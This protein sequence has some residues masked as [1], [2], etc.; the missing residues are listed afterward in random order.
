MAP[1]AAP[2]SAYEELKEHIDRNKKHA[3]RNAIL[4]GLIYFAARGLIVVLSVIVATKP[5]GVLAFLDS[6]RSAFALGVAVLTGL[7]SWLNDL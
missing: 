4:W 1:Q 2:L 7:D 5:D 3:R 6:W